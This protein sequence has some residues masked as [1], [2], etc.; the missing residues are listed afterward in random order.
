[1]ESNPNPY[2]SPKVINAESESMSEL[3]FQPTVST[4][5][6]V[7]PF[8]VAFLAVSAF[9]VTSA[10]KPTMD[11]RGAAF[12]VLISATAAIGAYGCASVFWSKVAITNRKVISH[13]FNWNEILLSNIDYWRHEAHGGVISIK[14]KN[15]RRAVSLSNWAMSQRRN[16]A[17]GNLLREK[18]G[19]PRNE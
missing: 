6:I 15:K 13:G 16:I 19:P 1:M 5:L 18:A 2:A 12:R 17:V 8:L 9:S 10:L 11:F 3:E 4:Y 14:V 7:S